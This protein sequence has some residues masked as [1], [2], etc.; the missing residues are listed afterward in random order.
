MSAEVNFELDEDVEVDTATDELTLAAGA[1]LKAKDGNDF[2]DETE[3]PVDLTIET[4]DLVMKY[5][6]VVDQAILDMQA[7]IDEIT[8]AMNEM[9]EAAETAELADDAEVTT[10]LKTAKAERE[11]VKEGREEAKADAKGKSK[12]KSEAKASN[13]GKG[14]GNGKGKARH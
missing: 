6:E 10:D 14:K 4:N 1:A 5:R 12:D 13:S 8:A 7:V 3:K 9:T 11:K 2:E